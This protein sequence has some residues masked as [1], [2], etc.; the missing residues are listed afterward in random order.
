MIKAAGNPQT[1]A[2]LESFAPIKDGVLGGRKPFKSR[3]DQDPDY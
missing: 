2:G 3:A 1:R